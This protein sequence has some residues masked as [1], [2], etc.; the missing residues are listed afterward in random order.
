[1]WIRMGLC[2]ALGVFYLV[3]IGTY[4]ARK[5]LQVASDVSFASLSCLQ[6]QPLLPMGL[7]LPS[8][9]NGKFSTYFKGSR[10][11]P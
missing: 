2:K 9:A 7:I 8:E 6:A 10:I 1:M 5:L 4:P 3:V 11:W